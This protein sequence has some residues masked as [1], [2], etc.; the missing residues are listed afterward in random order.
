MR[1]HKK[2]I[3]DS[4]DSDIILYPADAEAWHALDYFDPEFVRDPRNTRLDLSTEGFQPYSSDSTV[5]FCWTVL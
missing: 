3:H 1:W 4:K 2:E 5:Y